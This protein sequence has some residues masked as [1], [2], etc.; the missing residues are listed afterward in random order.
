MWALF[1]IVIMLTS[2][3]SFGGGYKW[4]EATLP[5]A[6]GVWGQWFRD[7]YVWVS[8]K[9]HLDY[10]TANRVLITDSGKNATTDADLTW[11]GGDTLTV[12]NVSATD[13]YT[14][15]LYVNS[16]RFYSENT[17]DYLV[18]KDTNYYYRNQHSGAVSSSAT[19]ATTINAALANGGSVLVKDGA[20]S[21]TTS[22]LIVKNNT[23]LTFS[24]GAIIT[25]TNNANCDM[26]TINAGGTYKMNDVTIRGG[27]LEGNYINEASG[28]GINGYRVAYTIIDG[29]KI[30]NTKGIGI[31]IS[32]DQNEDITRNRVQN[33]MLWGTQSWGL[34]I[35]ATGGGGSNA[36]NANMITNNF[37]AFTTGGIYLINSSVNEIVNNWFGSQYTTYAIQDRGT[38]NKIVNNHFEYSPSDSIFI[39]GVAGGNQALVT[40][41]TIISP[42]GKGIHTSAARTTITGNTIKSST[43]YGIF[44]ESSYCTVTSNTVSLSGSHGIFI[45]G[46]LTNELVNNNNIYDPTLTGIYNQASHSTFSGNIITMGTRG[47]QLDT[48][49]YNTII[50][51]G[52]TTWD[53]YA[54]LVA[55]THNIIHSNEGFVTENSGTATLLNGQN[56]VHVTH[57]LSYTPAAKDINYVFTENPTNAITYQ[58]I[59]NITSSE[60]LLFANDPGAS[61]LDF[62]WL[63][64]KTP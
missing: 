13:I 33:C 64:H 31:L 44:L 57:G 52:I 48:C 7:A 11:V 8:T 43:S 6:D 12:T 51:N 14:S 40:G 39:D 42:T 32:T 34:K 53:T 18:W 63:A 45:L 10:T 37:F 41:N 19:F 58:Y 20:Y 46:S 59:G 21:L 26:I 61:N 16:N 1:A 9:L 28:G 50:G 49:D 29:I 15:S 17:Y 60:F 24:N 62:S 22:M 47:I 36:A 56:H 4:A 25:L 5:T 27:R 54:I 2:A 3:L 38:G 30:Y 23:Q 55:G 35:T